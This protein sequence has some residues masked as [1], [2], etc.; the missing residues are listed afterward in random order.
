[1]EKGTFFE[2]F[3]HPFLMSRS[4]GSGETGIHW[5]K[6]GENNSISINTIL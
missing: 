6:K 2:L 1:M 5:V 3:V 4:N